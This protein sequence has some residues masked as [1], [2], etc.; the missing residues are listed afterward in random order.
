MTALRITILDDDPEYLEYL[1]KILPIVGKK[2]LLDIRCILCTSPEQITLQ[3]DILILDIMMPKSG[4]EIAEEL[5]A[6]NSA[7]IVFITSKNELVFKSIKYQPY[8]F[9]RKDFL[10]EDLY[11]M[12]FRFMEENK[13]VLNIA[14]R[15]Y[16][17]K[18]FINEIWLIQSIGNSLY[19]H[20]NEEITTTKKSVRKLLKENPCILS[21]GIIQINRAELV[22]LKYIS[23][24][25][26]NIV[27]MKN[28]KSFV[29]SKKYYA[30]LKKAYYTT[31]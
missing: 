23:F 6:T 12:L 9:I 8:A 21:H 13:K 24:I 2:M 28:R 17:K 22:N 5:S 10:E 14:K 27:Q 30:N 7:K 20:H 26:G 15:G 18:L 16:I 4:F 19:I 25:S 3:T 1:R 31:E 11:E 29:V